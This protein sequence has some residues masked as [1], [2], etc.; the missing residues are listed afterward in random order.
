M[1]NQIKYI[2]IILIGIIFN[3]KNTIFSKIGLIAFTSKLKNVLSF[4]WTNIFIQNN[5]CEFFL[6]HDVCLQGFQWL[7]SNM[8]QDPLFHLKF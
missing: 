7:F 8:S 2:E 4:Y 5:C 3:S 6:S 1:I